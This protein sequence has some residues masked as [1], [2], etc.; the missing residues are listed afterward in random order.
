MIKKIISVLLIVVMLFSCSVFVSAHAEDIPGF[1]DYE[2]VYI[3]GIDGAGAAFGNVETPCFDIIFA[4]GAVRHNAH[5][6]SITISAQNW[7][8]ILTGVS[9]ETHGL[10]NE[11]CET[12]ERTS[13]EEFNSIFY[14]VRE[15]YPEAELV[16]FN[17][18]SPINKGIIE[19]D[20]NVKKINKSND[21]LVTD[22]IVSYFNEGNS[23]ALM[24][25]QL[26]E[27]DHAAHAYGGFSEKY[28]ESIREADTYI[29]RIYEAIE[30]NGLMEKGLFIVV[31]DHGETHNGHGGNTVEESSAVLAVQGYSVSNI[32]FSEDVRNRDV[33]AIAL[34][35]L[36]VEI[37]D[38]MTAEIPYGLYGELQSDTE[39]CKHCNAVHT[40]FFDEIKCFFIKL[41][42]FFKNL[43]NI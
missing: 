24:F 25:V 8:S 42:Q 17:N 39:M 35:A 34:Y 5:T 16:S 33:A 9:C 36:G 30:S 31:A 2:H 15:K 29:G 41:A 22:S 26:D 12:T 40:D 14:F 13:K 28:Y 43:F 23:P 38:Y 6:E 4:D 10:T 19:N 37:P 27:V 20:I 32:T 3:I 18:W 11:I 7:G 1:G 21:A